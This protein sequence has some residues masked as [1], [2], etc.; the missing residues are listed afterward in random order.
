[1][2]VYHSID[3]VCFPKEIYGTQFDDDRKLA[4]CLRVTTCQLKSCIKSACKN[5]MWSGKSWRNVRRIIMS[6]RVV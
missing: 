2:H 5:G 4:R 1:M 3:P 6:G